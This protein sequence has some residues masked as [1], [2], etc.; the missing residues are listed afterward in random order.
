MRQHRADQVVD[1]RRVDD[2]GGQGAG[3]RVGL[4]Q[5]EVR[6]EPP[7]ARHDVVDHVDRGD[8]GED[9]W[10]EVVVDA[11][12]GEPVARESSDAGPEGFDPTQLRAPCHDVRR[13]RPCDRATRVLPGRH[14][15]LV[16]L[17]DQRADERQ[18]RVHVP[19]GRHR[20]SQHSH[21]RSASRPE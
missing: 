18:E 1:G 21:Q 15:N 11:L 6:N 10:D 16:P 20:H 14:D 3:E 7:A 5:H 4:E 19:G 17:R 12:R 9:A 13:T 8:V 2:R